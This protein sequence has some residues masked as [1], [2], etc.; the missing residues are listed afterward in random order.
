MGNDE[1]IHICFAIQDRDGNYCQYLG[2]ALYSLLDNT[3][4]KVS[5]HILHDDTLTE[6]NK[7]KL[8][9]VGNQFS[10]D[11]NFYLVDP[12]IFPESSAYDRYSVAAMYRLLLAKLL[13]K[14]IERTLYLD[15][16]ILVN[17]DVEE[18]YDFNI[19][20]NCLA[21]CRNIYGEYFSARNPFYDM[22]LM[23]PERYINDGIMLIN[24][25]N[26]REQHDLF[27]ETMNFLAE[28]PKS[29]YP[30]QDAL[31]FVFKER[32]AFLPKEY[33][34]PTMILRDNKEKM[35]KAIY[36]YQGD[37]PCISSDDYFDKLYFDYLV[38]TPWGSGEDI[39][40]M[41]RSKAINMENKLENLRRALPS[42]ISRTIVFWGG[43]SI[44][45][46]RIRSLFA[47]NPDEDYFVDNN[48]SLWGKRHKENGLPIKNPSTLMEENKD[49]IFVVVLSKNYYP[50]IK[51][52]LESYGFSEMENFIDGYLLLHEVEGGRG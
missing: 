10:A 26:I 46:K 30:D 23:S 16:D 21:G 6:D 45:G 44:Q 15:S 18:L 28:Y 11:I 31:N 36:H 2:V 8:I 14:Y 9:C 32:I 19:G 52:Q 34:M 3:K 12:A 51:R 17:L 41:F 43:D 33:N 5:V 20:D 13:P 24:L 35:D 4:R 50:D 38:K 37:R 25:K 48:K 47:V 1:T 7:N 29:L 49:N 40:K 22:G 39:L 27:V 42:K